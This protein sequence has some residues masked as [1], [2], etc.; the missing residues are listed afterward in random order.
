MEDGLWSSSV[1]RG[2][3][4]KMSLDLVSPFGKF[5]TFALRVNFPHHML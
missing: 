5:K 2:V 3:S 1:G 4:V